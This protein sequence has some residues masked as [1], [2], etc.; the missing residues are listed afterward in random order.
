[1]YTTHA[2]PKAA[3]RPPEPGSWHRDRQDVLPH[4]MVAQACH[5]DEESTRI[6]T[7]GIHRIESLRFSRRQQKTTETFTEF[8]C[9]NCFTPRS[10]QGQVVPSG[11]CTMQCYVLAYLCGRK[12][13]K[14]TKN[15]LNLCNALNRAVEYNRLLTGTDRWAAVVP[16]SQPISRAIRTASD[17]SRSA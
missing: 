11:V 2:T 9:N 3:R 7:A 16:A 15:P 14:V 6:A 12:V 4:P 10:V 13:E 5:V 1:M 17:R 8:R